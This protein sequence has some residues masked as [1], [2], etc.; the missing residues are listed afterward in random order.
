MRGPVRGSVENLRVSA[1]L[2]A[3]APDMHDKNALG[4]VRVF[5]MQAVEQQAVL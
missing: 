3:G 4:V 5:A 2:K 1:Q